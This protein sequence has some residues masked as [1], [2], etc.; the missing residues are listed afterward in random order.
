MENTFSL[1]RPKKVCVYGYLTDPIFAAYSKVSNGK[2]K[3]TK[4][5][6]DE[7]FLILSQRYV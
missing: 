5:F 2:I 3:N 4:I 6:G 7:L 1:I